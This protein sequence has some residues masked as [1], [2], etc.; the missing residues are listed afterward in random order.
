MTWNV[1]NLTRSN[2][3]LELENLLND[4]QPDVIVLTETELPSLDTTL[5]IKNYTHFYPDP[6]LGKHRLLLA[7]RTA[8]IPVCN[9]T[10]IHR[11]ALDLWVKLSLHSGPLVVG[12]VYRQWNREE[13]EDLDILHS[14]AAAVASKYR[15]AAIVGDFNLDYSRRDDTS[16]YRHSHLSTHLVMMENLGFQFVGPTTHTF[17]S[18]GSFNNGGG[19]YSSKCSTLDHYYAL[20][21]RGAS[22]TAYTVPHAATD[23]LPVVASYPS[24]PPKLGVKYVRRRN[25]SAITSADLL[26]ALN[27]EK[28]SGVF[29][30]E[31]VNHIHNVLV[32][33]ITSAL[34][35]VAPYKESAVKNRPTPLNLKPDT[36]RSMRERDG[37]AA[38]GDLNKYRLLRNR[39]VRLV[40]RDKLNSNESSL[41]R[42]GFDPK[43]IWSL[44]NATLGRSV[45][46]P[47]PAELDGVVG[48]VDLANHVNQFYIDKI[49]KLLN[50]VSQPDGGAEEPEERD[51]DQQQEGFVLG[52][53][54]EATVLRAIRAL[55]NTGAEGVD[56]IPV[57]VLK[58]GA[59]VLA[60]PI[61]HLI[62]TSIRTARVPDG[63][64]VA[65]VHPVHKKK[66]PSNTAGSYRP[67][68]IL[69]ALSK[70]M[71]RIVHNQLM[72]YLDERLPNSQ[73]GFRPRRNTV[74]AIVASHG[75]WCKARVE[76]Q[77]V[78]IAAYDLSAAFDTLDH[79]TL[80]RK[81]N[82]L[83]IRGKSNRW[84]ANYLSGRTQKVSYNSSSSN[85]LPLQYG[86]PQG[87]I[88]GPLLFLCLLVDLPDVIRMSAG[89]GR[90]SGSGSNGG[91]N[92]GSHDY[93]VGCS[94]Y[95]DDCIAWV[96]AQD[97]TTVKNKLEA[98]S[99]AISNY[100]SDHH[101][102]LNND[103]T[104]ILW[105]G[106]EKEVSVR[107]GSVT[108]DPA[109]TVDVLGVTF[110]KH[111]S[112]APY[113]SAVLSSARTIA[114]ASRRLAMHLRQRT[115]QQVV[116]A[117]LVGKVGYACAVLQPR[118]K[119]TDPQNK[120][121]TD[122]Q[123]AINDC[124]RAVI[125]SNRKDR[126]PIRDLLQKAGLPSLNRLVI[127]Q[128]AMEC[129]KSMNYECN[130]SKTP[131]GEILCPPTNRE[132]KMTRST[133]SNCLPPPTKFKTVTFA[134]NAYRI[135]NSF[136]PLRSA[137]T[138]TG[139]RRAAKE[140]A[141]SSPL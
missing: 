122:I 39:V 29:M 40:K 136:P 114:G 9:P 30:S 110:D 119:D 61:A 128:I 88:L 58:M 12:G 37:A 107:V 133:A 56:K 36:L 82:S 84:F 38:A 123:T 94:G 79:D 44:A 66:K 21:P 132:R 134:W 124:A 11:S 34:D 46:A 13:K 72:L 8:L 83:G 35:L 90:G 64:K 51:G 63:F 85:F 71:E 76:G 18:Y 59:S 135:W 91:N 75:S 81:L 109:N 125:G 102:V 17:R 16:Y 22:A 77:V 116:R 26:M 6:F 113:L 15:R 129:W 130:G 19:Y 96:T 42:A 57:C 70:V 47:L 86:V 117:L 98:V 118:L 105:V 121:M 5:A 33:E 69:P 1:N 74:G 141:E 2:R 45:G 48:D 24:S 68:S 87:S 92:G 50:R 115:L 103:K 89:G 3:E 67:V 138:L 41:A 43:Q 111:L 60:A 112:V 28:L 80:M 54:T 127:E 52:P 55:G 108:V 93:S 137:L 78:G 126:V 14:H 62:S 120:V 95:A 20:G 131:I 100:M 25:Y 139:A 106:A 27:A 97:S 4:V 53:I 104:Q 23:H 73:H 49:A 65:I 10:V 101:L 140:L 32:Q 99:R 7:V 31:D